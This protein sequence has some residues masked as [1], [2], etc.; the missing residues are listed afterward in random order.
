MRNILVIFWA[1]FLIS[2]AC[3]S[4]KSLNGSDLISTNVGTA[5]VYAMKDKENANKIVKI[6]NIF[7][8][9]CNKEKTQCTYQSRSYD[10]KGK[11]QLIREYT[12]L[13]KDGA[14]YEV[15]NK[16]V[17]DDGILH[18]LEYESDSTIQQPPLFTQKIELNKPEIIDTS[19]NEYSVKGV[20]EYT[21]FIP[22]ITINGNTYKDCVQLEFK[23]NQHF[24]KGFSEDMELS[25]IEIYCKGIGQVKNIFNNYDPNTKEYVQNGAEN[26]LYS[27]NK[28]TNV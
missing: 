23:T 28:N 7:V 13:V 16:I 11:E 15:D 18:S 26:F 3:A 4:D 22:H 6:F 9:S 8:K 20:S 5:Y 24:Y 19:N 2:T 12:Y 1:V 25:G 21:K 17:G 27:V 10:S 14:V